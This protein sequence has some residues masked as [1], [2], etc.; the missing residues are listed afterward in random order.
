[1]NQEGRLV[2]RRHADLQFEGSMMISTGSGSTVKAME[3]L[4]KGA[5]D[6]RLLCGRAH[7]E[8]RGFGTLR[9]AVQD[10]FS[11]VLEICDRHSVPVT[12]SP[13]IDLAIGPC[14]CALICAYWAPL[15]AVTVKRW[16]ARRSLGPLAD[17]L[18][19]HPAESTSSHH[20]LD[21]R[22]R[23][24]PSLLNHLIPPPVSSAL[25]F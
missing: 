7:A 14:P 15:C 2:L 22:S 19:Q 13:E 21:L 16:S 8:I 5:R 17:L 24:L 4:L 3:I 23:S 6:C 18:A 20:F 10:D 9:R 12:G 11:S 25:C 1:M